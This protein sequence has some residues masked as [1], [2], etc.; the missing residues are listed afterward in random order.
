MTDRSLSRLAHLLLV[1]LI[2]CAALATGFA[3]AEDGSTVFNVRYR[4][5]DTVYLEGGRA[6]GLSVGD[7]LEI[8][9]DGEVVARIEVVHVSEHSSSCKI[10]TEQQTIETGDRARFDGD[11]SPPPPPVAGESTEAATGATATAASDQRRRRPRTRVSGSFTVDWESFTDETGRGWDYD[12]LSTRLSLRVKDI[13]F[14]RGMITV[15]DTKGKKDRSALLPTR[16]AP[17]LKEQL[18]KARAL[19][20]LLF[21]LILGLATPTPRTIRYRSPFGPSMAAI[22]HVAYP[23][24]PP[25]GLGVPH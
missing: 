16:L 14:A 19:H 17:D 3:L 10:L 25:F 6:A 18:R 24:T 4:S 13:D 5:A 7:R 12:R 2:G 1:S 23:L 20:I 21:A 8:V 22:R 9:R 15:R 11:L